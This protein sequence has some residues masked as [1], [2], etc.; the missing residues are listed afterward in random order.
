MNSERGIC[1]LLDRDIIT[2]IEA[3][4]QITDTAFQQITQRRILDAIQFPEIDERYKEVHDAHNGTFEWALEETNESFRQWLE[5]GEGAFHIARKPGSG[6]STLMKFLV[7][8]P[9]VKQSLKSW[10]NTKNKKLVFSKCFLWRHGSTLQKSRKGLV[11][12]L[13][14]GVLQCC[15][16]LVSLVFSERWNDIKT[17]DWRVPSSV[18]LSEW[19]IEKAFQFL[20]DHKHTWSEYRICFFIDGLD[21][22]EDRD[23]DNLDLVTT[24]N[25]WIKTSGNGFKLCVSSREETESVDSTDVASSTYFRE[26][27]QDLVWAVVTKAEGVFLWV[28]LALKLLRDDI[29]AK[30]SLT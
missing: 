25:R 17:F 27:I 23:E 5:T 2:K 12:S 1:H 8:Q 3:V 21:E 9:Q 16:E 11:H 18:S 7:E 13:L 28:H 29:I 14:H 24:L 26:N 30:A 6:K 22:Y 10:A 4:L 19:E 15:P 20:L